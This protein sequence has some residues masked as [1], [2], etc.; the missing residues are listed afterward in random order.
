MMDLHEAPLLEKS[1]QAEENT[2]TENVSLPETA[3]ENKL[4][5]NKLSREEIVARVK[6]LVDQPV[7]S[8]KD[9]IDSL[10]Q[11]Y[12]KLRKNEVEEARRKFEEETGD[13]SGFTP[14]PDEYEEALKGL[15]NVFKEK[16]AK[17]LEQQEKVKE[18]NLLR[19]KSILEEIKKIIED[20]D[21]INKHYNDFQQLQQAFKEI[22]DV[23]ASAVN[24]LW[25][26]YQLYV[27]HFYDL[28]K[29]NKEL[30]DYDFKKNL[31]LKLAI[32]ESAEALA[33]KDDVVAAFKSLQTLHDEWRAIGP[34][35][36]ELREDL[37]NR[38]KAASTVI[39]KAHQQHFEILKADE[40]KNEAAK[41]AICEEIESIDMTALKSFS[42]WDEK[43]KDIIALQERWKGIG[44]ASR[45]VNNALFERF[46]KTCD[47]F[48][49]Q[50]AEYFKR[51]KDEM[52]LNLEKKKALCEKA[53][54]LK[55]STDWKN[56]TDQMIA[57]QKEWKTIGPVAKKYSDAVWTRFIAA[58]DYFFEQKNKQTAS[59][60]QVEQENLLLKKAVIEK[61][62]ALD[63]A[64]APTEAVALVKTLMAEWNQIGHV[65]FKEKDKIY[66]SYQAALD[67]HFKRLNMNETK[68]RL[69]SFTSA[70]QQ[71]ASSDQA[72]NKLYRE[73][74]RLMRSYEHVKAELQTYEN[75]MGF[76]N[77]SSKSGGGMLKEMERK[78]QKLKD[79]MQLIAQ[80]IELIDENL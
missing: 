47:E 27:E 28:L 11:N 40:Q 70:V 46:R 44:F 5:E 4:V 64:M 69:N 30:R 21:N 12:Y 35:A 39:N 42:A 57:I 59:V 15:L 14:E 18:E 60:R 63:E 66:K 72:Q 53:E 51:V 26:N 22:T 25:K 62:N 61:L 9:E 37:W 79:E 16:K 68:N 43:T 3:K 55:D 8:V 41:I 7:E 73:R 74:E 2:T 1:A 29:I 45:K 71:M 34:V 13:T 80:K 49:K 78:M 36:K 75:N 31:D 50:K 10:K 19:K 48:F 56:T 58:C 23:P 67:K 38:F 20:S 76:L 77:I 6:E 65:P 17:L 32:C 33:K 52:S 24:E 54:A